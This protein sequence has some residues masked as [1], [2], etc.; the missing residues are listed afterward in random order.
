MSAQY[1]A[2]VYGDT[3]TVFAVGEQPTTGWKNTFSK[4]PIAVYPPNFY[5]TEEPPS[6]MALQVVT[7]FCVSTDF[8]YDA[9]SSPSALKITDASGDHSVSIRK[10]LSNAERYFLER[11]ITAR[12]Y[13]AHDKSIPNKGV[14]LDFYE[15]TLGSYDDWL[16]EHCSTECSKIEEV[17]HTGVKLCTEYRTVC[18]HIRNYAVLIVQVVTLQD[19]ESAVNTALERAAVASAIAALCAAFASG[20]AAAAES[21]KTTFVAVLL[22]ELS[23]SLNNIL[24]VDVD[25]RASWV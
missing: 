15:R 11:S 13:L 24:R 1:D 3:V 2:L 23:Q 6:G 8:F 7:P 9:V 4:S 12:F 5:F 25:F 17:D 20:G 10:I 14:P 21:A 19:I 16:S 22:S 18:Q